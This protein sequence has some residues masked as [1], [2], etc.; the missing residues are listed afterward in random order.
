[1]SKTRILIIDADEK[2]V[3]KTRT[4]LFEQGYEVSTQAQFTD[5]R[6]LTEPTH[7]HLILLDVML[8]G[9]SGFELMHVIRRVSQV[10]VLIL[11]TKSDVADRIVGL[12]A[13]ADDY[14]AK[15]FE[16]RELLARIQ[17]IL[18]R[19][20]ARDA[21]ASENESREWRFHGLTVQSNR[22][23]VM[24]DSE[25]VE[26]TT[27]EFDLLRLL[28]SHS[29]QIMSRELILDQLRGVEWEAVDRSIDILVSR[30]RDKLR[31]D[32]R[33]PRFIR[34][35]RSIGYQFVGEPQAEPHH[36]IQSSQL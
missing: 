35:V 29:Q 8:P 1:M 31:D 20:P 27:A 21:Q 16:P 11:T 23:R 26:L 2:A 10:P 22:R 15:P 30:L 18:R 25:S 32:P 36:Q 9:M 4:L 17:S 6:F 24:L 13:G 7:P 33:R 5:T 34:T 12:E 19:V 14:L 28:V 3:E